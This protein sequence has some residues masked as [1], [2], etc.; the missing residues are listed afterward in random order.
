MIMASKFSYEKKILP[1][2]ELFKIKSHYN[3]LGL[4]VNLGEVFKKKEINKIVYF[5]QKDKK[6]LNEK[7]NLILIKKIG[8]INSPIGNAYTTTEI[9]KFLYSQI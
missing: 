3:N 6:N 1:H 9:K 5:M 7:I 8:K 4:P 2:L